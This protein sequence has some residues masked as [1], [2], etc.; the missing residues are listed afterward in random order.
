MLILIREQSN[1]LWTSGDPVSD[2]LWR[3]LSIRSR[4]LTRRCSSADPFCNES[5]LIRAAFPSVLASCI[6]KIVSTEF[7]RV[8]VDESGG[9]IRDPL[10]PDTLVS[11]DELEWYLRPPTDVRLTPARN[12]P[13]HSEN[14]ENVRRAACRNMSY[15]PRQWTVSEQDNKRLE[16]TFQASFDGMIQM[17]PNFSVATRCTRCTR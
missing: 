6:P 14:R 3:N 2:S 11:L 10:L 1:V 4:F 8:C 5:A 13:C 17:K 9:D 7:S 15:K 12:C 16:I